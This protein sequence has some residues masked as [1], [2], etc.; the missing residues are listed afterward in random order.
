[1]SPRQ[2][3]YGR[4]IVPRVVLRRLDC[5]LVAREDQLGPAPTPA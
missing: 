5:V 3:E 1:M 4:V 2:S